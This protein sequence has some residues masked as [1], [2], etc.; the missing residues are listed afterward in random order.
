MSKIQLEVRKNPLVIEFVVQSPPLGELPQGKFRKQKPGIYMLELEAVLTEPFLHGTFRIVGT[1]SNTQPPVA[2]C[3]ISIDGRHAGTVF[4]SIGTGNSA[5]T[6]DFHFP[7]GAE[8]DPRTA[9]PDPHDL[10][11]VAFTRP[12]TP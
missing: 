11:P 3:L 9:I 10:I 5:K 6:V 1:G 8:A 7:A 4:A 2:V 12:K